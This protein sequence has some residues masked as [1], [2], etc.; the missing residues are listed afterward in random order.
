MNNTPTNTAPKSG[1]DYKALID[2]NP[3]AT[4]T[5]KQT[6]WDRFVNKLGFTSGYDRYEAEREQNS[7]NYLAQIYAAQREEMYNSAPEQAARQRAAGL[8]PDITGGVDSGAAAG[9]P[10]EFS[11]VSDMSDAIQSGADDINNF[12][13]LIS[14]GVSA[15]TGTLG[16]VDSISSIVKR[17]RDIES[18]D[19]AIG[20]SMPDFVDKVARMFSDSDMLFSPDVVKRIEAGASPEDVFDDAFGKILSGASISSEYARPW[21]RSKRLNDVY[22]QKL[23]S[24]RNSDVYKNYIK[25]FTNRYRSNIR[26]DKEDSAEFN[27]FMSSYDDYVSIINEN[28]FP[29]FAESY[30]YEL[31]RVRVERK[32]NKLTEKQ[33]A[34]TDEQIAGQRA[35]AQAQAVVLRQ[36]AN[37]IKDSNGLPENLYWNTLFNSMSTDYIETAIDAGLD[38]ASDLLDVIR[39]PKQVFHYLK[40]NGRVQ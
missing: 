1:S 33:I 38:I 13:S 32:Q 5:R 2:A 40:G 16:V 25:E 26:S 29:K 18:I 37:H 8:N 22:N 35:K 12:G 21:F 31:E 28:Y 11:P 9:S 36:I 19:Y 6:G 23:K 14:L 27:A 4:G 15:L 3:Y 24:F 30:K 34:L 17:G 10:E 39:L 7:K 20:S